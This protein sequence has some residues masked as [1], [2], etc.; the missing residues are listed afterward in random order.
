MNTRQ[1]LIELH[2]VTARVRNRHLLPNTSWKIEA[3][4][5][6][7][8]IG[9]NGAGKTTLA[10][11]LTG[12]VPLVKG[13]TVRNLS[14]AAIR[15]LSFETVDHLIAR[16]ERLDDARHFAARPDETT[17]VRDLVASGLTKGSTFDIQKAVETM[18]IGH[19]LES[20]IRHLSSGEFRKALL[21]G[22][23][24]ARPRLLILDEPYEGLDTHAAHSLSKTISRL[25]QN[26]IGIV[27]ITHQLD[28]ICHRF[29]RVL[30]VKNGTVWAKG[31]RTEIL[32]PE[33]ISA[34]YG[35]RKAP[36]NN[37]A[38][39]YQAKHPARDRE[40]IRLRDTTVVYGDK[41]V[42][43][44]LNWTF[45]E[46]E[47]WAVLGPN[48]SGKSTLV[49]LITG[50]H[51]QAYANQVRL[52]GRTRGSGESI[53]EIKKQIGLISSE[54]QVRYRQR[55]RVIDVIRS[56]FFDSVGL[57]RRCSS[58]QRQL[59]GH[60]LAETGLDHKR[61]LPFDQLSYGQK[62][63]V[64][65]ARAMVKTPRLLVMDEPC[66]GLDPENRRQ[67]QAIVNQIC[68]RSTTHLLF[69]THLPEEIPPAINRVL[70]L[71]HPA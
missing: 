17:T 27:L 67:I 16:E 11:I 37:T 40:L 14:A 23:L 55:I 58:Q 36:V 28:R 18:G 38:A 56:G 29:D 20:G 57:Y 46:G 49:K 19:L 60:W 30:C 2:A 69:I 22:A 25:M 62:R 63:L 39:K 45:R 61:E 1:S 71:P 5:H 6:W 13:H 54:L 68:S 65:L 64:L 42:L 21:A 48:G 34:L 52:F 53:W 12:R 31:R 59:A 3:G 24:A 32:V 66:L 51:P 44:H 7:A 26:D 10:G 9:P 47:N 70:E 50:D 35:R 43:D 15:S 41:V 4:C 8:I 33:N